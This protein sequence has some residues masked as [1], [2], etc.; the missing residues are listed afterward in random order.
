M[1]HG[2]GEKLSPGG[3]DAWTSATSSTSPAAETAPSL[4]Q[5]EIPFG[6]FL[7][8]GALVALFGGDEIIAWY[9]DLALGPLP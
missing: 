8:I 4:M 6:V 5:A 9:V 1:R 3:S 7:G 2:A